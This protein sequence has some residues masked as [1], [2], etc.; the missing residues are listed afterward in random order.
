[1][2]PARRRTRC[3]TYLP[4]AFEAMGR[5]AALHPQPSTPIEALMEA[6]PGE[7]PALSREEELAQPAKRDLYAVD[8]ALKTLSGSER[9][10]VQRVVVDGLSLRQVAEEMR[11]SK[12]TVARRRDAALAKLKEMLEEMR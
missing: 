3:Y 1:M 10:V 6:R 7:E 8:E 9:H 11:V 12:T 4:E 5:G 2:T